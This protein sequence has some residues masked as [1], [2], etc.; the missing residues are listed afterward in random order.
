MRDQTQEKQL[1]SVAN[2]ATAFGTAQRWKT[3]ERRTDRVMPVER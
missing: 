2:I 3:G 1:R